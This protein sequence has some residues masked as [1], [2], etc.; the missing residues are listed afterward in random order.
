M[1]RLAAAEVVQ[2]GERT[3]IRKHLVDEGVV[4]KD[5]DTK[6]THGLRDHERKVRR[7]VQKG[8]FDLAINMGPVFQGADE[9]DKAIVREAQLRAEESDFA[10]QFDGV[11]TAFQL[12][13]PPVDP[14]SL[15]HISQRLSII[16]PIIDSM[17]ANVEGFGEIFVSIMD[18]DKPDVK[19]T[20]KAH[21]QGR[22]MHELETDGIQRIKK[23]YEKGQ[24]VK[25][26]KSADAWYNFLNEVIG[27]AVEI[28]KHRELED[29]EDMDLAVRA[30][31]ADVPRIV[32]ERREEI[33]KIRDRTFKQK[34]A[35]LKTEKQD[36]L[37]FLENFFGPCNV[38]LSWM[39]IRK[40]LR[41]DYERIGGWSMEVMR[42]PITRRPVELGHVPMVDMRLT[43]LGDPIKAPVT[44]RINK[45]EIVEEVRPV[46]FRKFVQSLGR[47]GRFVWFKEFGDPRIMNR[48]N[49][50]YCGEYRWNEVKKEYERVYYD[51]YASKGRR[52]I[53]YSKFLEL[54][55]DFV[56]A[57]EILYHARYNAIGSPY[58]VPRWF[59][60]LT[61]AQG[62]L[63]MEEVNAGWF[64]NNTIPEMMV[65]VSD[66][67]LS[68]RSH[69]RVEAFFEG[70]RGREK[71][72][73][74]MVLE[75]ETADRARNFANTGK[76]VIEIEKLRDTIQQDATH[77]QYDE[78]GRLKFR[79][80]WRLPPSHVGQ[81]SQYTR[82]SINA[83]KVAAEE[84]VFQPERADNDDVMNKH[85]MP[86]LA[87]NHWWYKS[88][89]PPVA[90]NLQMAQV[91]SILGKAGFLS[92]GEA[93]PEVAMILNRPLEDFGDKELTDTPFPLI[94]IEAKADAMG[95][96]K[97]G[98]PGK[99]GKPANPAKPHGAQD[100]APENPQ[101]K[102]GARPD[103][104]GF[105][106][107]SEV[108]KTFIQKSVG[109]NVGEI[110]TVDFKNADG[111]LLDELNKNEGVFLREEDGRLYFVCKD[112]QGRMMSF[113]YDKDERRAA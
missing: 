63:A 97:P 70:R 112:G 96:N 13:Q 72:N 66:G 42:N 83:S 17:K 41:D 105:V 107:D 28:L 92:V 93:R 9:K 86:A 6:Y 23:L 15:V 113:R 35:K 100:D 51:N 27:E 57:N 40:R 34:L 48:N 65:M 14:K 104:D 32:D 2:E 79:A 89:S 55:P 58:P 60:C 88:N 39:Q 75:A 44:R 56:E 50:L 82:Q 98:Q 1:S 81:E 111:V 95:R 5:D 103:K 74:V 53:P 78:K 49:G 52:E 61:L 62:M 22:L 38:K 47:T 87:I 16:D 69:K 26:T 85:L 8:L 91:L 19:E 109:L 3:F 20:L 31:K 90:D 77:T 12:I 102:M 71:R 108:V 67:N 80:C 30:W 99:P 101:H 68:Q 76:P 84:Q 64:D 11:Y 21:F 4:K 54:Y 36:E 110:I 43:K 10:D 25:I 45:V 46:K 24:Q 59:G 29:D 37:V 33:L 7:A 106:T 18:F 94:L 73:S